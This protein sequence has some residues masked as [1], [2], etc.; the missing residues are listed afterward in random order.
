MPFF[1]WDWTYII[2]LPAIIFALYAQSRVK[3][4]YVKY[5]KIRTHGI[6][7][8][9]EIA[10]KILDENGL[11]HIR[12]E[13]VAGELTDHF[14]PKA[15]VVRLSQF[16]HNSDSVAAIGIA[17]HEVGHAIQHSE[18]YAP[19]RLRE[20]IIPVTKLGSTLAFPLVLIGILFSSFD[21]LISIGLVLY[22]AVV[23]FQLVTLPV[24]FNA[25]SRALQALESDAILTDDELKG[26]RNVLSAA[27]MTY[28]AAMVSSLLT[29]LRLLLISRRR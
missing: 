17:A 24:E 12:I 21:F 13:V 26:A 5:N 4:T 9:A 27:A 8:A 14:D 19:I 15:M 16:V 22:T 6:G 1:L 10:R 18:N 28:V 20:T 11:Q 25:S 29:L 2:V 23:F 7:T 3:S